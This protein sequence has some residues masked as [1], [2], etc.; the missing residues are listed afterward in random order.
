MDL[1]YQHRLLH[2]ANNCIDR[3]ISFRYCGMKSCT[4]PHA[5]RGKVELELQC[6]VEQA[7]T[8]PVETSKWATPIIP[9][10]KP[11][12]TVHICGDYCLT[13]NRTAK[14]DDY[15]LPCVKDL[16]A[17]LAGGKFFTKL[18]LAHAYSQIPLSEAS[19]QYVTINTQRGL[20][21][22]NRLPFGITA[23][24]SIFPRP[25]ETLLQG[26]PHV[27]IYLDDILITGTSEDDYLK[28]LDQVLTHLESV[29]F[30]R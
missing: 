2:L 20:Y 21:R 16:F 17:T 14:P 26:I 5:V 1:Y 25:M 29:D 8:E 13:I 9:V 30:R 24:P 11:H 4:I 28:T 27:S 18:D 12:G 23:A 15:P 22:Y 19:K 3:Y 7:V 10:M 6:L